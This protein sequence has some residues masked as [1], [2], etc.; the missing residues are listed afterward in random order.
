MDGATCSWLL[1]LSGLPQ[2]SALKPVFSNV[3][4]YDLDEGIKSTLSKFIGDAM[5]DGN[6]DLLEEGK[7]A[8]TFGHAGLM[9]ENQVYE[10]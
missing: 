4:I 5:S 9:G 7:T 10:V 2:D 8:K 6:V 1:V 3:F